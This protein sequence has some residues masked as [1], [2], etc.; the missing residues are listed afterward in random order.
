MSSKPIIQK[1]LFLTLPS[2]VQYKF[3]GV[4]LDSR[5]PDQRACVEG[6]SVSARRHGS[7]FEIFWKIEIMRMI[8]LSRLISGSAP[9]GTPE[10]RIAELV[11]WGMTLT[12]KPRMCIAPELRM[13][14]PCAWLRCI[15]ADYVQTSL[16]RT[17]LAG[18]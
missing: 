10:L 9:N 14:N 6:E 15:F 1:M 13:A 16:R 12:Q 4:C 5:H 17:K 18:G 3:E 11:G 2:G 8:S 7:R